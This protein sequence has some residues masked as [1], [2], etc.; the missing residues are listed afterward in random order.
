MEESPFLE[1]RQEIPAFYG[2]QGSFTVFITKSHRPYP[3]PDQPN[4]SLPISSL[5]YS[6]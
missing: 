6:F 2:T 4:P 3:Q 5:K 1:A